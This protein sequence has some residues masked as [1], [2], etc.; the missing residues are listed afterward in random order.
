MLNQ[1][2][3]LLAI[4]KCRE[5]GLRHRVH[6]IEQ[7]I[8]ERNR[9]AGQERADRAALRA[10][11]RAASE[12]PQSVSPRAFQALKR[13][14]AAFYEREQRITG[15]L[16]ELATEVAGRRQLAADTTAALTRN[17]RGQEKLQTVMKESR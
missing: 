12:A 10:E 4:K 13:Q 15:K 11:W 2:E 6:R 8:A 17:L 14:F 1:L 3:Q 9:Q 7:E 5:T 16:K